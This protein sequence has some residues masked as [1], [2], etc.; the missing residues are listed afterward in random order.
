M[1]F[2]HLKQSH[3]QIISSSE[4]RAD[5]FNRAIDAI[6][7]ET[8]RIFIRECI[9]PNF[10]LPYG[11]LEDGIL[12]PHLI[13]PDLKVPELILYILPN[14]IQGE[15]EKIHIFLLLLIP[16]KNPALQLRLLQGLSS[17]LPQV[18]DDL[19]NCKSEEDVITIIRTGEEKA[20]PSYK[21]LKPNQFAF[22]LQTD[23]VNGLTENEAKKRFDHFGPNQ[24][25]SHG[26]IPF[27]YKLIKNFFSFFAILL[28]I[29]AI[30]CFIP[31]V[32]MPQ[33]GYAIII[34]VILN[35]FFSFL[36]ESRSDKA[37]E[38]LRRLMAHRCRVIREGK[39]KEILATELV[40][41]DLIVLQ[42]GDVVP[43]D[44]RLIESSDVEIDNSSLTGESTSSKRYKSDKEI[45][46]EGKFLWLEMPNILFAGTSLIKGQSKAIVFG[47]G[48]NSEIGQIAL[49]TSE[50]KVE[51]SPLQKQLQSTVFAISMLALSIA[52][53]F[54][55]IGWFG[56]GLTF[57]Q[58]FIFCIGIFVANVPEGLLPTVTLSLAM[59]VSRMAKSNAI[60][61]DLS[62]VETLG[63]TTVICSDKTGT[64]TQNMMMVV[65]IFSSNEWIESSGEGYSSKGK[66]F[67]DQQE[68]QVSELTKEE[69]RARL[70]ACAILCNNAK[71]E[72][73]DKGIKVIGDPT[74]GALLV[75]ANRADVKVD[76]PRVHLNPFESVRK[77]MSVVVKDSEN[78]L[79]CYAKGAHDELL[80]VCSHYLENGE[81][82]AIDDSA[83]IKITASANVYATKGYRILGFAFREMD[84]QKSS[85]MEFTPENTETNL[86]Y[87]GLTAMA[88]PIRPTVPKAIHD[89]HTA[90]IRILMVTGD[91]PLT[92]H[93]IAKQIGLGKNE[94]TTRIVTGNQIDLLSEIDL[95]N[96]VKEGEP[97]FARVSP[98][99]KLRIVSALKDLG[100]VVAVTGDGVN[101]G[102]ALKKAD[103]GI[104][105]GL[106]G[107]DV[108][109]EAS[110]MILTD[111]NFS[112]IVSAIEEGRAVFENIRRF[113]AYVLNSNPQEL[114]PFL[115]WAL[116]PGFPLLMTVMGVLAVDVGTD[117]VPAMGLGV[118]APEKGI[119]E[120]PP[121]K[122]GEKLLSIGFILR[123]YL[124]QGSILCFSCF[125]TW[126][127]FVLTVAGGVIPKSPEG[128][129]MSQADDLYLQSLTAF[130]VPTIAVQIANVIS[131][132]SWKQSIFSKNFLQ[133]HTQVS[134]ID[135]VTFPPLRYLLTK[136]PLI[137]NLLSNKLVLVGI[138][139]ELLL[140]YLFIYTD[141]SELYYF[142]PVPWDV[143]LFALHG[144]VLLLIFE[145]TKKYFR[146]KGKNL[147]FLG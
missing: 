45:L 85:L 37:V 75:L 113:S 38:A 8:I 17:L 112:S 73:T 10:T 147:E 35:G 42:E 16:D 82:K 84:S 65:G 124:V 110:R 13:V 80:S 119:M 111:D 51:A 106:R 86:I 1:I 20:K 143:Y 76:H 27:Y 99:Q 121:R 120:R 90:G 94:D 95:R 40:A 62:S 114:L 98:E 127:Y 61:K 60:V 63:C 18:Q 29:A 78:K 102:P 105:M 3:I 58:A 12:V 141:L 21:N 54:L 96:I 139:F 52:V 146:R 136:V 128:L 109:K 43:A 41:G 64:L 2:E 30:L 130:F 135:K 7:E 116:F 79:I 25:E 22:E 133:K 9:T 24:L 93:S 66:F 92:A 49:L 31:G 34:V 19:I 68:I 118:E 108:A 115:L 123:S 6:E 129:D 28:W 36:Q 91:H 74:E 55:F 89:C 33:L 132:R 4:S 72:D 71:L 126:Y 134:L 56:A 97:I 131:K 81:I 87:L 69:T 50:I 103:I 77:R 5:L 140:A 44:C 137:M 145:E 53:T 100:E 46:L 83:R 15:K 142:K 125:A 101:D 107:T 57:I 48:M 122:K 70:L 26:A 67:K 14:G 47:T 11:S 138:L 23:F 59:G 39:E 88:D 144:T 104:A 117:L 32:N